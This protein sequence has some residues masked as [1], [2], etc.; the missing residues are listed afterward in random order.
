MKKVRVD[1]FDGDKKI[2][3]FEGEIN[4]KDWVGVYGSAVEEKSLAEKMAMGEWPAEKKFWELRAQIAKEHYLKVF[5]NVVLNN[6]VLSKSSEDTIRKA[7]E[8]A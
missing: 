7:L 3:N 4:P 1:V 6:E 5:D 8:K 2:A